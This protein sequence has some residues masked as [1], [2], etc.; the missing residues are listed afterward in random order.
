MSKAGDGWGWCLGGESIEKKQGERI[1]QDGS[2]EGEV[3]L[4]GGCNRLVYMQV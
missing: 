2:I 4:Y 3:V 1:T